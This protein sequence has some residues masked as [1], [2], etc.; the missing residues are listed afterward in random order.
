MIVLSPVV[1][2]YFLFQL[3]RLV[4]NLSIHPEVGPAVARDEDTVD[5]LLQIFGEGQGRREKV[6]GS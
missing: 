6:R 3:V 1:V 5:C 2:F 4:A